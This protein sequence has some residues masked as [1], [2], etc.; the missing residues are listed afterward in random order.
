MISYQEYK[1]K[2]LTSTTND[3]YTLEDDH[4]KPYSVL[5]RGVI[6]PEYLKETRFN[7]YPTTNTINKEDAY[8]LEFNSLDEY[9]N[10]LNEEQREKWREYKKNWDEWIKTSRELWKTNQKTYE[11]YSKRYQQ[12]E[13]V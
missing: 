8:T 2:R 3:Y 5:F 6:Y 7:K 13:L 1:E 11:E 9:L 4:G 10:H 12:E